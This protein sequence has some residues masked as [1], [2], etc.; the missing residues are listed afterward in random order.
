MSRDCFHARHPGLIWSVDRPSDVVLM[1]A[2]LLAP[3]FHTLLDACLEFGAA[4]L[5]TEWQ[6]LQN[7]GTLEA[8]RAAPEVHRI[9]R[10]IEEGFADAQA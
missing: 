6:I 9:L 7:E 3:R 5:R 8:Q 2:A 4:R 10:H 1:R